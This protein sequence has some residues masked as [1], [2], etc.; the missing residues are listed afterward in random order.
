MGERLQRLS[1][2][3]S[4]NDRSSFSSVS[5]LERQPSLS[6]SPHSHSTSPTGSRRLS[7]EESRPYLPIHPREFASRSP[8]GNGSTGSNGHSSSCSSLSPHVEEASMKEI[9]N[10]T[11]MKPDINRVTMMDLQATG[12]ATNRYLLNIKNE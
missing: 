8:V 12:L 3:A 5:P 11:E 4:S 2:I 6:S 9:N 1:S 7:P 10:M